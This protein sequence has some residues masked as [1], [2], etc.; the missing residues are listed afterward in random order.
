MR[1]VGNA[2]NNVKCKLVGAGES[3]L[4]IVRKNSKPW[5]IK[6]IRTSHFSVA[7]EG[8]L[9]AKISDCTTLSL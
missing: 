3:E 7:T 4:E 6:A 8:L 5:P 9:V 2:S 1:D